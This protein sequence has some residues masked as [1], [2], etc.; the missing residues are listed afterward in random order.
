MAVVGHLKARL[1]DVTVISGPEPLHILALI[2]KDE[3]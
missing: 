2:D 3:L 1:L